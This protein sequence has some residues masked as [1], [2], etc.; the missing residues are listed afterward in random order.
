MEDATLPPPPVL[1]A[2]P[3]APAD[4]CVPVSVEDGRVV[5]H[6]V[7]TAALN[8]FDTAL[9][10]ALACLAE[11]H[12]RLDGPADDTP[13]GRMTAAAVA[14]GAALAAVRVV[15]SDEGRELVA[16]LRRNVDRLRPG[17][18]TPIVPLV[19][20]DEARAMAAADDLLDQGLLV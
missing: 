4:G 6:P 9:A 19:L 13:D 20:G 11:A 10:D 5:V 2:A 18:P 17:H 16:R 8:A 15:R 14:V 7:G 3:A 1:A 12:T